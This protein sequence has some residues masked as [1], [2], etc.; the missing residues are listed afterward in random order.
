MHKCSK[1]IITS[2][3]DNLF[4]LIFG[5]L[6]FEWCKNHNIFFTA[7]KTKTPFKDQF[8]QLSCNWS[9]TVYVLFEHSYKFDTFANQMNLRRYEGRTI[10]I[11]VIEAQPPN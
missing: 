6:G 5:S 8:L 11:C 3:S 2:H 7:I 1:N 10:E 9:K 4:L